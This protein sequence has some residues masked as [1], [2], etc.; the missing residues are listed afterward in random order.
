MKR[1]P[2][3]INTDIN[4]S[5][6]DSWEVVYGIDTPEGA[7]LKVGKD[8]NVIEVDFRVIRYPKAGTRDYDRAKMLLLEAKSRHPSN[9]RLPINSTSLANILNEAAGSTDSFEISPDN[10]RSIKLIT[11]IFR[12]LASEL[13]TVA[14]VSHKMPTNIGYKQV[15]VDKEKFVAKL[16]PPVEFHDVS[17]ADAHK[18]LRV[19]GRQMIQSMAEGSD[20]PSQR[21]LTEKLAP[22]LKEIFH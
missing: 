2:E 1:N 15:I 22:A 6:D 4:T 10:S 18:W 21:A 9:L 17:R 11:E 3:L 13:I 12:V 16:L 7:D 19:L 20:T 5:E 8:G 14:D